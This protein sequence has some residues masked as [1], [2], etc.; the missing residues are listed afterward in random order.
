[1]FWCHLPP[2]WNARKATL[3]IAM[4]QGGWDR[5]A[6]THSQ[7]YKW[8]ENAILPCTSPHTWTRPVPTLKSVT[9]GANMRD[10]SGVAKERYLLVRW[11]PNAVNYTACL[12]NHFSAREMA[13]QDKLVIS[14]KIHLERRCAVCSQKPPSCTQERD[15]GRKMERL[16]EAERRRVHV[17][18]CVENYTVCV[19]TIAAL[20]FLPHPILGSVVCLLI[21]FICPALHSHYCASLSLLTD[22]QTCWFS[23]V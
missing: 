12:P 16:T 7:V 15:N 6:H 23:G 8:R 21:S 14:Q 4:K 1:M 9:D 10:V 20:F 3:G 2:H 19:M 11:K 18:R 22:H 5:R 13:S 17:W